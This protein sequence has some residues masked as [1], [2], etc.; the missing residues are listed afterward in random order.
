MAEAL[1]L[2]PDLLC[3]S[4]LR[5]DFVFQRPQQNRLEDATQTNRLCEFVECFFIELDAR[6]VRIGPNARNVDLAHAAARC[7]RFIRC[8]SRRRSSRHTASAPRLQ[9]RRRTRNA[10]FV[11]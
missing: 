11:P 3:F 1:P 4:H 2:V 9:R 5:W 7:R 6:L 10:G 8:R